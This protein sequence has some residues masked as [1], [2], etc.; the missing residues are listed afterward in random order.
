MNPAL[1]VTAPGPP[2][3]GFCRMVFTRPRPRTDI[4]KINSPPQLSLLP[5]FP[6][7]NEVA[8]GH[9]HSIVSAATGNQGYQRHV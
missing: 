7:Q 1:A 6:A 4:A 2:Y 8:D 3:P 5:R 9:L